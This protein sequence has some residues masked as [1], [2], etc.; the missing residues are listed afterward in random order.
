MLFEGIFEKIDRLQMALMKS[1][2]KLLR[3]QMIIKVIL[4]Y[5]KKILLKN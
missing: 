3:Y 1:I 5:W 2:L 4:K